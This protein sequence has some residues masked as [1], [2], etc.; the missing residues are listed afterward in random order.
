MTFSVGLRAAFSAGGIT[1]GVAAVSLAQ[2]ASRAVPPFRMLAWNVT[3]SEWV[4]HAD[5]TRAVLRHA[6]ADILILVEVAPTLGVGDVRRMVEGLR[7]AADTSWYISLHEGEPLEH[8]VIVSRDSVRELSEFA[9]VPYPDTG[10]AARRAGL[11]DTGQGPPRRDIV[12]ANGALV[13][14]RGRWVLVAGVHLTSGGTP[15]TFNEFR[16]Q[17]G[18]TMIRNRVRSALSHTTADGVIIAGDM[19]LVAGRSALDTLIASAGPPLG[20]MIRAEALH[21]DGWTDWTWDG[22]GTPF[23]GGRLDN[24]IY[25]SGTLNARRALV[26]DTEFLPADTL[27]A[28][29]VTSGTSQA[30]GR[31]RPIVVDLSF[32]R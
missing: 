11:V 15:Y 31:H 30:I 32:K 10:L 13:R 26:W 12:R 17:L 4:K 5:E 27:R 6:D 23:N 24:A 2:S 7:G 3:D 1:I 18:A 22:R 8:I 14:V 16:R 9:S 25:S 20:P 28:H 19:N 21:S 29:G